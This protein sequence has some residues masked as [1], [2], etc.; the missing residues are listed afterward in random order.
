MKGFET[1][2][3]EDLRTLSKDKLTKLRDV[4]RD[5]ELDMMADYMAAVQRR[6]DIERELNERD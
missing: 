5:Y 3:F 2:D 1:E 4:A 6:K